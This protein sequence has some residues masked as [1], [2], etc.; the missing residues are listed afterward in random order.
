MPNTDAKAKV[1]D[2]L[3]NRFTGS[4]LVVLA[5]FKGASVLELDRLRRGCEKGG[6]KLQVVKNTLCWRA[7]QGTDKEKLADHFRGNIAVLF[8]GA[9]PIAAAKLVRDQLK[10]N[11]K[12][13]IKTSYFD[14]DLLDSKG[15]YAVADLPGREELLSTLLGTIQAGPKQLLGVIQGAPRDLMYLLANHAAKIEKGGDA[16]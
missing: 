6:I 2:E 12:F 8:S 11:E 1:V 13:T 5:D 4:P 15:V 3:R 7:V 10:G 16:A 9:D 14:G